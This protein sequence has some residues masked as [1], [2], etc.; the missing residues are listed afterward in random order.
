MIKRSSGILMHI[1][2]LG[3]KYGMGTFGLKAYEFV[4]FLNKSGQKFWQILPLCPVDETGS[5]YQS[6]STFAIDFCF[7]DLDILKDRGLLEE[8][9][10]SNL[11]WGEF[12]EKLDLKKVISNRLKVLRIAYCRAKEQYDEEIS[13]FIK[14]NSWVKDYALFMVILGKHNWKP[15]FEWEAKYKDRD[16]K[17]LELCEKENIDEIKF[18]VFLQMELIEQWTNLK[19]YANQKGIYII[20][21]LPIYVSGNSS[22]VWINS[23]NFYL[24]KDKTPKK[25]SGCPP[26]SFAKNGQLWGNPVYRWDEMEKDGFS[27]WKERLKQYTKMFDY[28]RIDHFRGFDAFYEIDAK[29]KTAINGVWRKGPGIMFF[30]EVEKELGK[31]NLIAED[32]GFITDS[33]RTMLKETGYCGMQILQHSFDSVGQDEKNMPRCYE[34][35]RVLYIGTHD[36]DTAIGWFK[37]LDTKLKENLKKYFKFKDEKEINWKLIERAMQTRCCLCVFQMQDI[38]GL[39]GKARMN[40]PSTVGGN[41]VWRIKKEVNLDDLAQK[42]KQLTIKTKRLN[43]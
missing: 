22:D 43:P 39:D 40:T 5:A 28:V 10:Y 18:W 15:F 23:K 16:T 34:E 4:D 35:N 6:F 14:N 1:S 38:L 17:A 12:E 31:L 33:V 36:N 19:N 41:W 30:K 7:I 26:D 13:N 9:E 2:S 42:L 11:D 24:N 20:G 27:W 25:V 32:L 29:E 21:D 8:Q 37:N 3:S